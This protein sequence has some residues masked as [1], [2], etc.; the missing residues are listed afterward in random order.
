M[1]SSHVQAYLSLVSSAALRDRWDA[2]RES[3]LTRAWLRLSPE[4]RR[5]AL[6]L[7][8]APDKRPRTEKL[9]ASR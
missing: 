6:R 3:E 1:R 9:R 5:K 8:C 7:L 2:E 4:E